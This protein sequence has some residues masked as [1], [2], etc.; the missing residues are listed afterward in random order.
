MNEQPV[1]EYQGVGKRFVSHGR[2]T[3]ACEHVNLTVRH[4]E[5]LAVVGPSGCGKSTLLNMVAGLM[6]PSAGM[7][8]YRGEQV[9]GVNTRVGYMTQRD[10]LFPWRT[11]EDNVAISLELQNVA[12][13]ERRRVAREHLAKVGLGGFETAY[14]A[15]LSGGMRRRVVL[16]RTLVYEPETLLMDEP[17]GALDAQLRLVLQDELLRIWS[18]T[19]KT[20]IFVTHDLAEAI[21]LAD[22]VAIFTPR[23][24]RIKVV[25]E[26][27]LPR[28][29]NVFSL[30]FSPEFGEL[31]NRLWDHLEESVRR[32]EE[33]L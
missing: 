2:V 1:I 12:K 23:P 33:A 15:N 31:H 30:R 5:F 32:V 13:E 7:I 18:A 9:R 20:V 26:V 22:R 21:M 4:G 16:A 11:A 27:T 17:F 6:F 10:T 24:G 14:P 28:P 29:R 25:E 8:T 19:R 3:T